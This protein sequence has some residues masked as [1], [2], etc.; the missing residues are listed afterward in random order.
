MSN[1][2]IGRLIKDHGFGFIKTA[3]GI[4][5]FFHRSEVQ[6]VSFEMLKEGQ[7]VDFKA[8]L[9]HKGLKATN[10]KLPKNNAETA[11]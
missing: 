4:D 9:S 6:D 3:D 1:G 10:I 11:A 5:L 2:T 8:C 7:Q